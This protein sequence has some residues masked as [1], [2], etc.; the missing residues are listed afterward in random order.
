MF[1]SLQ[2]LMLV[3]NPKGYLTQDTNMDLAV[4]LEKASFSWNLP[5]ATNSTEKPQDP[6]ENAEIKPSLRNISFTLSKVW[7]DYIIRDVMTFQ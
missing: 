4:A 5:D 3:Q 2:K 1:V 7:Y 6:S